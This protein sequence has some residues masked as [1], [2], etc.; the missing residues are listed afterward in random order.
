MLRHCL[1]P[2]LGLQIAIASRNAQIEACRADSH[3][4]ASDSE[5]ATKVWFSHHLENT[6]RR[7]CRYWRCFRD[8]RELPSV[9]SHQIERNSWPHLSFEQCPAHQNLRS[10]ELSDN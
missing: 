3:C 1:R 8:V 4:Q 5:F 7:D 6:D 2:W 10:R 9:P